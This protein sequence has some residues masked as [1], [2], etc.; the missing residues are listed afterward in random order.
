MF[1]P[2]LAV[3]ILIIYLFSEIAPGFVNAVLILVL[4]GLVL[5]QSGKFA[6]LADWVSTI[7]K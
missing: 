1:Y 4:V 5:A 3:G 7:T 2:K 6:A